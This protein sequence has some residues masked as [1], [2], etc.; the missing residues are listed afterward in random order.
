VALGDP[1]GR[2]HEGISHLVPVQR[3]HAGGRISDVV[4]EALLAAIKDLR[5]PPGTSLSETE[6]ATRL[7]VSRTPIREA[8]ARLVEAGLVQ[9]LP[10]VGTRVARIRL[11]E[12]EQARFVREH[13]E[14]AAFAAACA[15]PDLDLAGLRALLTRQEEAHLARDI[16]AF[17]ESDEAFHAEIFRLS[18]YPVA[19]QVVAPIKLQLDRVRRLSMP[20]PGT[21][22][23]LIDEHAFIVEALE[24]TAVE[25]GTA[26]LR[27]HA[28]RVTEY[29]PS[30]RDKWP[31]YFVTDGY[32]L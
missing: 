10:Q 28:R 1:P 22:R 17:F 15:R 31:D 20:D 12:V 4:F 30:L 8:I 3:K 13:L 21:T 7:Q 23:D 11:D 9:V 24:R 2:G 25:S 32:V 5:L 18:G 27:Q 16:N 14:V 26:R 19:W 29:A 6:L